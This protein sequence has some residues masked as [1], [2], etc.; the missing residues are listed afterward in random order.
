MRTYKEVKNTVIKKGYAWFTKP[1]S[2]NMVWERTGYEA[3][4]KFTDWLHV[5]WLDDNGTEQIL[6]IPATTVPGLKG[7]LLSPLTVE[8]ITGTAIIQ[9]NQYRSAWKFL[10]TYKGFTKYPY[11]RQC[12][13]INYWRDGNKNK[14]LDKVQAQ[15]KKL[16][17]THWHRMSNNGTYGSGLVNNWS[18]GCMGSPEPEWRK[19]LPIVRLS[20][21]RYGNKFTGT[22]LESQDFGT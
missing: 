21:K 12:A 9:P 20:S 4:N 6:S 10:D 1:L 7:S 5:C 15:F 17:R 2:L 11:F 14:T 3:T 16:F 22:I 19:I 13:P 18:L 8:G